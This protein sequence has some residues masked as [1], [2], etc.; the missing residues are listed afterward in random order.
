MHIPAFGK[1]KGGHALA[2]PD[3]RPLDK[4]A[5]REVEEALGILE[6]G[7]IAGA[8]ALSRA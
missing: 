3:R 5:G 7:C 6:E 2:L 8:R 4:V 1:S